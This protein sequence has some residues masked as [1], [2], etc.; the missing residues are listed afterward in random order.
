METT[1]TKTG[2][3]LLNLLNEHTS[4]KDLNTPNK[5]LLLQGISLIQ[6]GLTY[7]EWFEGM[8][9]ANAC[10]SLTILR[11]RF[12]FFKECL[13]EEV[14]TSYLM[15]D[16]ANKLVSDITSGFKDKNNILTLLAE[17]RK[18]NVD[19]HNEAKKEQQKELIQLVKQE[20]AETSK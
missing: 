12:A 2:A 19:E 5:L 14:E 16:K 10:D 4:I 9:S 8:L 1:N 3:E 11:D 20:L 18:L 13:F 6:D 15:I 7:F 17:L